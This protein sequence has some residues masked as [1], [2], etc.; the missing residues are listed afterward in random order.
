MELSF[1]SLCKC[2]LNVNCNCSRCGSLSKKQFILAVEPAVSNAFV[3][4]VTIFSLPLFL[5][6][7]L[8]HLLSLSL[9]LFLSIIDVDYLRHGSIPSPV[10]FFWKFEQNN[11]QNQPTIIK[12]TEPFAN[13]SPTPSTLDSEPALNPSDPPDPPPE[14]R[15]LSGPS[16]ANSNQF[17]WPESAR[18]SACFTCSPACSSL[19][20]TSSHKN[21]IIIQPTILYQC[22][23]LISW[24]RLIRYH[25]IRLIFCFVSRSWAHVSHRF[26]YPTD[27]LA[28]FVLILKV[29]SCTKLTWKIE[30]KVGTPARSLPWLPLLLPRLLPTLCRWP[31]C[32]LNRALSAR[33]DSLV[34][35]RWLPCRRSWRALPE[36]ERNRPPFRRRAFTAAAADLVAVEAEA[37]TS[38]RFDRL[39]DP[40]HRRP[41]ASKRS[42]TN[43]LPI[44]DKNK[45]KWRSP[46]IKRNSE[47]FIQIQKQGIHEK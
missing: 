45:Y 37:V 32:W 25:L 1:F 46:A 39:P 30:L 10:F 3:L 5:F 34:W 17:R 22:L 16:S 6:L 36:P 21:Q 12:K 31:S 2:K 11:L 43:L 33:W 38:P 14:I 35:L 42:A 24:F 27:K 26:D 18:P 4:F 7:F 23:A 15:P 44:K 20:Q 8:T 47:N 29:W 41:A 19:W 13:A 9:C 40:R 28:T